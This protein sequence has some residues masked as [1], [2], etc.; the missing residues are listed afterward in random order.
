[1]VE[2][3][4]RLERSERQVAQLTAWV[5]DLGGDVATLVAAH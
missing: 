3:E 4:H 1:V 2:L 5:T